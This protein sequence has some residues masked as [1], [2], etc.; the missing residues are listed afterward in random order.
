MPA[1][2]RCPTLTPQRSVLAI[3]TMP[4]PAAIR[5]R[6]AAS[7]LARILGR[8]GCR[9]S[10]GR[11]SATAVALASRRR[12]KPALMLL[13]CISTSRTMGISV[14]RGSTWRSLYSLQHGADAGSCP[15]LVARILDA[16]LHHDG[17]DLAKAGAFGA[18]DGD[19]WPYL[20]SIG[21][22]LSLAS[23]QA[24]NCSSDQ[25]KLV[26][27][28]LVK[29]CRTILVWSDRVMVVLVPPCTVEPASRAEPLIA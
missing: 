7:T 14:V 29:F 16:S 1:L 28:R 2:T 17:S 19:D 4:S 20:T 6:M 8:P 25:E 12:A 21:C 24:R 27:V 3:R 26:A 9:T 13:W 11:P 18:Q 23:S 10:C 5:T 22:S 15:S